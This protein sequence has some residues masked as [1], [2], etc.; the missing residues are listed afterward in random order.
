[1]FLRPP[2]KNHPLLSK[3]QKGKRRLR[4]NTEAENRN[5]CSLDAEGF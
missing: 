4:K 3:I 1:M 2:F 5:N